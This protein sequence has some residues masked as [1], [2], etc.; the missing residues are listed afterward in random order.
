MSIFKHTNN[1]FFKFLEIILKTIF[2]KSLENYKNS[3]NEILWIL[4]KIIFPIPSI[5]KVPVFLSIC[6]NTILIQSFLHIDEAFLY[7]LFC[8][9]YLCLFVYILHIS[10]HSLLS[11]ILINNWNIYSLRYL[12]QILNSQSFPFVKVLLNIKLLDLHENYDGS[13]IFF[14][15]Y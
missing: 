12:D 15:L 3:N 8:T 7:I 13:W 14:L 10:L 5:S 2:Y 6:I 4:Y 1:L 11:N 9:L